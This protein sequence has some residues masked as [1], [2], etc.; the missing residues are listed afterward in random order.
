LGRA[1]NSSEMG[2]RV[3]NL[4]RVHAVHM[5][6][7]HFC[8]YVYLQYI[9]STHKRGDSLFYG[10]IL[11]GVCLIEMTLIAGNQPPRFNLARSLTKNLEPPPL[12][13]VV[14]V[15]CNPCVINTICRYQTWI[16]FQLGK[17][18]IRSVEWLSFHCQYVCSFVRSSFV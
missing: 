17:R 11:S 10:S 6:I 13:C 4:I 14:A 12:Q 18:E 7:W 3:N 5:S 1:D 8:I 2:S 9:Y 15:C 16:P